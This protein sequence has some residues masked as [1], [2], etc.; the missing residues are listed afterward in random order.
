MKTASS[1]RRLSA[2]ALT[3]SLFCAAVTLGGCDNAGP[4]PEARTSDLG[5]V[6]VPGRPGYTLHGYTI[7]RQNLQP[8][9]VYV[10][11]KDGEPMAGTDT[12][13]ISGKSQTTTSLVLEAPASH[14]GRDA[15]HCEGLEACKEKIKKAET[16]ASAP[17]HCD[18]VAECKTKL[19]NIQLAQ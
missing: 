13:Y 7:T 14:A 10:L 2:L 12:S 15:F 16:I 11:E 6:D 4:L 9:Y 3:A 1:T 8:H 5:A 19:D 17:F 18:S